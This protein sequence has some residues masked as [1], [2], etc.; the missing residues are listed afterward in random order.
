VGLAGAAVAQRD[1]VL[2]ALDVFTAGELE[3]LVERRDGLEVEAGLRS[4]ASS[5]NP[6]YSD[7]ASAGHLRY[8][9][10]AHTQLTFQAAQ[11]M[12]R[13]KGRVKGRL[14]LTPK[15]AQSLETSLGTKRK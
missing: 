3:G 11:S 12:G 2:A 15:R 8:R 7:N 13:V 6:I 5:L 1:H 9:V 4:V 10:P 14:N